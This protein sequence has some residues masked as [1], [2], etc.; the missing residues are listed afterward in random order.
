MFSLLSSINKSRNAPP[1]LLLELFDKMVMPIL[2]YNS[3]IWDAFIF[4][5]KHIFNNPSESIFE[6]NLL[7][8]NLSMKFMKL[9]LGVHSKT[10]NLAVRSELGREPVHVK[11]YTSVLKYRAR[12]NH[13]LK[14]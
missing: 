13:E 1:K 14:G 4:P 7:T 6:I 11:I 3:E 8:E 12:V 2:L 5:N 9:I 10:C